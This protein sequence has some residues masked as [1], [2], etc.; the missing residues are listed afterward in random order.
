[1]A[2]R[3]NE[4]AEDKTE[5]ESHPAQPHFFGTL[6]RRGDI[7]NVGLGDSDVRATNTSQHARAKQHDQ[8]GLPF[9]PGTEREHQI[10]KS[11]AR[12]AYEQNR[13]TADAVGKLAPSRREE[14]LHG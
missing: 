1:M 10:R 13:T 4:R 11:R 5:P 8:G 3:S 9:Q 7:G 14:K 12:R 2:L 6:F